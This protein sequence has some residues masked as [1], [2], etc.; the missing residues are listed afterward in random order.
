LRVSGGRDS[1]TGSGARSLWRLLRTLAFRVGRRV[2]ISFAT[3]PVKS[4][5]IADRIQRL[6]EAT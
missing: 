4:G 3:Q 6:A 1:E 5:N 2:R